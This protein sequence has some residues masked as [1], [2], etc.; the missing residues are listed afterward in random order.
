MKTPFDNNFSFLNEFNKWIKDDLAPS[1]PKIKERVY[2][3]NIKKIGSKI[4]V[5]EGNHQEIKK[6]FI[7]NGAIVVGNEEQLLKLEVNSGVFLIHKKY[8]Y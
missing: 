4:L 8:V 2:A 7:K 1:M 3:K 5:D 6:D